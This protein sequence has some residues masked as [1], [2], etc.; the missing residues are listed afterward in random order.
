MNTENIKLILI[1]EIFTIYSYYYQP[2]MH[3]SERV[4]TVTLSVHLSVCLFVRSSVCQSVHL[5]VSLFICL[6]VCLFVCLSV[7]LSVCLSVRLFICLSVCSSV[8]LSVCLFICLSVHLSVCLCLSVRLS[9]I[10]TNN[11]IE[12][13]IKLL[14]TSI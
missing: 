13:G 4:I 2:S 1:H 9:A 8:C 11:T 14:R 5:S 6:S 3:M 7:H 10:N 12:L